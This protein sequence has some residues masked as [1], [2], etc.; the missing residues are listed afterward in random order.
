MKVR[1]ALLALAICAAPLLAAADEMTS[2][3]VLDAMNARR[4]QEGLTPLREDARLDK[5]A[6]DRIHDMEELGYWSHV[7]PDGRTPFLWLRLRNY[8]YRMA[9][10]NLAAGFDTTELMVQSWMESEGHR[11]NIMSSSF[12]D[13]GIAI[14]EGSTKGPAN[15]HSV[16]V[17]FGRSAGADVPPPQT[18][19]K[20]VTQPEQPGRT[21]VPR[22]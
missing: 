5:A 4:A 11:A 14:I 20:A 16:V 9:G 7:A 17:L 22:R 19:A 10:E 1:A 21:R 8:D 12:Q 3:A 6:Q 18:V 13:C 15:G 2:G